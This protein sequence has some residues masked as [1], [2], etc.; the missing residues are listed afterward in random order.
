M[1][2]EETKESA[3]SHFSVQS[4]SDCAFVGVAAETLD[5]IDMGQI[6]DLIPSDKALEVLKNAERV[7]RPS[8]TLR[9][10]VTDFDFVCD[11]YKNGTGD[12]EATLCGTGV[13]NSSIYNRTK[14][15][16]LV[17][18]AGF[19]IIS[20]ADGSLTWKHEPHSIGITARKK[21]RAMPKIPFDDVH[22]IMSLPRVSWTETFAKTL[23][24]ASQL[25]MKFTK[26]TGVFWSQS[27]ERMM[28]GIVKENGCKYILTIDYDSIFDARDV[29]RLWQV[30]ED[31]PDIAALCPMQIGR[32]RSEML[33][34]MV[35]ENG[36][37]IQT[38]PVEFFYRDAIDIKN[39]HFGLTLI[40]VDA[41][42]DFPHPWFLGVPN[43]EGKWEE[44]RTDDD[45]YFWH[46]MRAAG[47]RV[48]ATPKVRIGHLQCVITWP[49]DDFSLVHQYVGKFH[50]D[51]RP[52][53]CMTY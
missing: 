5:S 21:R 20:A 50:D 3:A 49:K 45:I 27:L 23:E 31:N 44:R 11:A 32:D 33:L 19:E 52:A 43:E 4:V 22:A 26:S 15:S 24:V 29:I 53:E 36:K 41:L 8:G 42:K 40:R 12:P 10:I 38:A 34:N 48:C 13:L 16:E 7:M 6:M 25:Q 46:K 18:H 9:M 37:S 17:N 35:D 28:S 1:S 30:M 2:E 47:K 51:G 39:G 14:V